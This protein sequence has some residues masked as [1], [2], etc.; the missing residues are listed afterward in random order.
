MHYRR[1]KTAL[2]FFYHY[3]HAW[4]ST[5]AAFL[6]ADTISYYCDDLLVYP[7]LR[8][9]LPLWL[10][11]PSVGF[12]SVSG[13]AFCCE[14][15]AFGP[16]GSLSYCAAKDLFGH[17]PISMEWSRW[18]AFL[19][20]TPSSKFYIS[21]LWPWLGLERLWVVVS[22]RGAIQVFRMNEWI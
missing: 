2:V 11:L 18:A 4:C 15:W 3:L 10:L 19:A 22:W 9:L 12:G 6:S 13:A 8:P 20:D 5:L 16:L 7:S 1:W 14:G 21:I 17:G